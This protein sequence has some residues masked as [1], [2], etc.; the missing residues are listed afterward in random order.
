[1]LRYGTLRRWAEELGMP[2]ATKL[3]QATLDEEEATDM[4][5]TR[6]AKTLV[7]VEAEQELAP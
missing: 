5:L 2:D 6:L 1:M 7:N 4:A 3:L